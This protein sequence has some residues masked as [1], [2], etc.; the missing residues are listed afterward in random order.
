MF[1]RRAPMPELRATAQPAVAPTTPSEL[2]EKESRTE[3]A[4][5]ESAGSN[6]R[7]R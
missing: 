7:D 3:G 1:A 6:R 4:H 2:D 5:R